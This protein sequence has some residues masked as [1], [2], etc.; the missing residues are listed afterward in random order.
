[1]TALLT[2]RLAFIRFS[3]DERRFPFNETF[4]FDFPEISNDGWNSTAHNFRKK[5]TNLARYT[6]IFASFVSGIFVPFDFPPG[7]SGIF[8]WFALRKFDSFWI[9]WKFSQD[10]S[11]PFGSGSRFSKFL[12]EWKAPHITPQV[13]EE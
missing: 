6:E 4:R 11:V 10:T 13:V 9:F 3:H 12:V 8:G 7:I 5:K 1:L 2:P